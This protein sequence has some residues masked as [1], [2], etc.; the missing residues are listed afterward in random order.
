MF[1]SRSHKKCLVLLLAVCASGC[2]TATTARVLHVGA[3]TKADPD[4]PACAVSAVSAV[5]IEKGPGEPVLH[6]TA[7]LED[8][9]LVHLVGAHVLH[10]DPEIDPGPDVVSF[11][12]E[13]LPCPKTQVPLVVTDWSE[14]WS[15]GQRS[16][17]L[18]RFLCVGDPVHRLLQDGSISPTTT[19]LTEGMAA[20]W[21]IV[22]IHLDRDP[23]VRRQKWNVVYF[24]PPPEGRSFS[25]Y[26]VTDSDGGSTTIDRRIVLSH[27]TC[28]TDDRLFGP[29][30][31][32]GSGPRALAFLLVL[33]VTVTLD[34]ACL[35]SGIG[36]V[37]ELALASE[38][39]DGS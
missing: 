29:L 6:L 39:G 31:P 19:P 23:R 38:E 5:S 4:Q 26:E 14:R 16:T 35:V 33:P 3:P 15:D 21:G 10:P 7:R 32:A 17:R 25:T 20:H 36:V 2:V 27:A 28:T 13:D 18:A 9:R 37:F 22:E 24:A 8:G 12:V 30:P 11:S 1:R 34:V